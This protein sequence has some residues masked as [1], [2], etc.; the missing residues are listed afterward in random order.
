MANLPY[1]DDEDEDDEDMS[2]LLPEE[3]PARRA[4]HREPQSVTYV[5]SGSEALP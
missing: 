3:V 1:L 2:F 4:L 5:T